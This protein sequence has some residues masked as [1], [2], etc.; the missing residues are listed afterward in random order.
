MPCAGFRT[1]SVDALELLN[2]VTPEQF[3]KA[4]KYFALGTAAELIR[5]I[6]RRQF[7]D[8][9]LRFVCWNISGSH[10]GEDMWQVFTF[11]EQPSVRTLSRRNADEELCRADDPFAV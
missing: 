1:L 9:A 7:D 2:V 4:L 5:T 8:D 6:E 10:T 3:L 11:N